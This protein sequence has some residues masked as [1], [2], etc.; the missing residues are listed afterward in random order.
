[1]RGLYI[2][3]TPQYVRSFNF[4]PETM[5]YM[6]AVGVPNDSTIYYSS[7]AYEITGS[8]MWLAVDNLCIALKTAF[9]LT[10]GESNLSTKFDAFYPLIGGTST[11]V[12]W[13]LIDPQDTNSAM[14][15]TFS[16]GWTIGATGIQGNG[17]NAYASTYWNTTDK[18][19]ATRVAYGGY[20]QTNGTLGIFGS[21]DL[22]NNTRLYHFG[23]S[24]VFTINGTSNAG[25]TDL[26]SASVILNSSNVK[27]FDRDGLI[28]T[29]ASTTLS[30]CSIPFYL[31]ARNNNNAS[32]NQYSDM[33]I[34]TYWLTGKVELTETQ[35]IA[36]NSAVDQFNAE[37]LRNV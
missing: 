6:S 34:S 1:M 12:K 7:T 32:I 35:A 22:N 18:A 21:W 29:Y 20:K 30:L 13:N 19:G 33:S 3:F 37:L 27:M 9:S 5:A 11:T 2:T 24:S 36:I 15:L 8:A 25:N 16:G 23:S 28:D 26:R 10:L 17:T 14:R 4:E 31:G